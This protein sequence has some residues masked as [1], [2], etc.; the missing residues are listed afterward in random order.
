MYY[1]HL[2]LSINPNR[3]S[4]VHLTQSWCIIPSV[5]VWLLLSSIFFTVF[6]STFM[7]KLLRFYSAGII[8]YE[9]LALG[10]DASI[11]GGGMFSPTLYFLVENHD[12][13]LYHFFFKYLID[14]TSEVL[15]AKT[16]LCSKSLNYSLTSNSGWC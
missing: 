12:Y 16:W 13:E 10:K 7:R 9:A 15:G 4:G 3:I 6:A 2:F 14:F 5:C 1:I 11:K 8:F